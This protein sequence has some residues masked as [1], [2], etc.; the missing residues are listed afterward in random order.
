MGWDV[1][2]MGEWLGGREWVIVVTGSIV[3]QKS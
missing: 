1:L 2:V 3:H